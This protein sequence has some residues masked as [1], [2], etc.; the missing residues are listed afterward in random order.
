MSNITISKVNINDI[1]IINELDK[2]NFTYDSYN[3]NTLK[4]YIDDKNILFLK[5]CIENLFIGYCIVLLTKPEAELLKICIDVQ[6]RNKGFSKFLLNY[7]LNYLKINNFSVLY[8]EVRSD[9]YN[10]IKLYKNYNF[11]EYNIRY[12]YYKNPNCD[13]KLYKKIIVG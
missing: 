11:I 4:K 3:I 5:V 2:L 9:N 10:A 12:N 8:L 7:V 1:S 13:A 6:Y